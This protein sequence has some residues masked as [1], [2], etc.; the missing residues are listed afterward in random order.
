[1]KIV[2]AILRRLNTGTL[3]TF[4]INAKITVDRSIPPTTNI[5]KDDIAIPQMASVDAIIRSSTDELTSQKLG[6][7]DPRCLRSRF[8]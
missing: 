3:A 1:M 6:G 7:F 5:D 8:K 2:Y 4:R